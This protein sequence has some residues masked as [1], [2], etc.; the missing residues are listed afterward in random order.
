MTKDTDEPDLSALS[1]TTVGPTLIHD[2]GN[3]VQGLQLID[4]EDAISRD[5][6]FVLEQ[7]R[8]RLL[9]LVRH[10]EEY[11]EPPIA[12]TGRLRLVGIFER[13]ATE[14]RA[15][16]LEHAYTGSP[17]PDW[18]DAHGDERAIAMAVTHLVAHFARR[19]RPGEQVHVASW[20]DDHHVGFRLTADVAN[21]LT[22]ALAS[23]LMRRE[24]G[25]TGL[26]TAIAV[27]IV[28]AHGGEIALTHQASGLEASITMRRSPIAVGG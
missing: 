24:R 20:S 12:G 11:I 14:L 18:G 4:I 22:A 8:D 13:L 26:E 23:P 19:V 27:R 1:L 28:R 5:T 16:G 21:Q 7:V 9:H 3:V 10:I 2:L 17:G 6:R 25:E 15:R